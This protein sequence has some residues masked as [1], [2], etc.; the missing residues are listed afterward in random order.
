MIS[1]LLLS[2]SLSTAS[3]APVAFQ[4]GP[5]V[6]YPTQAGDVIKVKRYGRIYTELRLETGDST[7]DMYCSTVAFNHQFAGD[8]KVAATKSANGEA[9]VFVYNPRLRLSACSYHITASESGVDIHVSK[10]FR[11]WG[12]NFSVDA[13]VAMDMAETIGALP[14]PEG[15]PEQGINTPP[16]L[17]LSL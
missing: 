8:L 5:A 1:T 6:Q 13:D 12:R 17:L 10:V 4:N 11:P 3:A 16:V 2:L 14:Y 7:E 9:E 15:A